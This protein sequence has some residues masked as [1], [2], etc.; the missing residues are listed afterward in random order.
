MN[1]EIIPRY[2]LQW[3]D[4]W[5]RTACREHGRFN[6]KKRQY[7]GDHSYQTTAN[8]TISQ[9]VIR[10]THS[11]E[12]SGVNENDVVISSNLQLR[13]DGYPRNGQ[14]QPEDP[15]VAVYWID[16]QARRCIAIDRYFRVEHNIAAIAATLE[17]LRAIDRHGSAEIMER[18]YTGFDALPDPNKQKPWWQTLGVAQDA[19]MDDRKRAYRELASIAHPD[20]GGSTSQMAEINKAWELAQQ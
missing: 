7:S 3:P 11:L 2:P 20:R 18:A 5:G 4:G 16:G 12:K 19:P 13:M 14:G 6:T 8:L 10:V 1:Q 9:A 15:G 17:A